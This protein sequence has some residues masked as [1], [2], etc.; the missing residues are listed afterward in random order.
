MQKLKWLLILFTSLSYSQE[1]L[2]INEKEL[3]KKYPDNI[4]QEDFTTSNTRYLYT[5][6]KDAVYCCYFSKDSIVYRYV[7]MH[8]FED[9]A[10]KQYHKYDKL[11]KSIDTIQEPNQFEN[12]G[13]I[14]MWKGP[15]KNNRDVKIRLYF[16][17]EEQKY[18]FVYDE[19]SS[20]VGN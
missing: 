5:T 16:D 7:N 14:K 18:V 4:F 12:T 13:L 11:Y 15:K 19:W 2:F 1:L 10:I 6:I 20:V 8:L 17:Q 3:L 9:S